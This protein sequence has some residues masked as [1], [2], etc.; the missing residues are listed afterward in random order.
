MLIANC[1]TLFARCK[2][3]SQLLD[4]LKN[5]SGWWG[6]AT[7]VAH[8]FMP[9]ELR[10]ACVTLGIAAAAVPIL[11]ARRRPNTPYARSEHANLLRI[12]G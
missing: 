6:I 12:H 3:Y 9:Y 10:K 8:Y 1:L 5:P 4:D 11:V 2:R 7:F